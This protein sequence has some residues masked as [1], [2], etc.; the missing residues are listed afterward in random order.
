V[1]DVTA[2]LLTTSS[3]HPRD[4]FDYWHEMTCRAFIPYECQPH[5]RSAFEGQIIALPFAGLSLIISGNNG[6]TTWRPTLRT[7][8]AK[9]TV[10]VC[11]QT[12]GTVRISQNG[13]D[14]VLQNGDFALVDNVTANAFVSSD[15]SK[16]L[17]IELSRKD[18]EARLGRIEQWTARRVDG[19][20]GVGAL[21][22]KFVRM[23][24][25]QQPN[26][27]EAA[28]TQI[29][30]QV[31]DLVSLALTADDG[32]VPSHSSARF[33]SLLRLKA[34]VDANLTNG[35]ATCEELA[36]AA[37][38]SV[39]YANQLLEAEQ[40]SLQRLL[41]SRRIAKCQAA[42][43]DPAQSHRQISDIAYSWGFG[44]VSHF[45][46]LF[47]AMVGLTPRDFRR[48]CLETAALR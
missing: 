1:G 18:L 29:A 11:I 26:L 43:A 16:N 44:D 20:I 37:G 35:C 19:S 38:I 48:Q 32:N 24:P 41:F 6:V 2:H 47:K 36:A 34:A 3:V 45:G 46:R 10:Y 25:E 15:G 39:R 42:L 30:H 12:A 17:V 7:T 22:S 31:V 28:Q 23:L 21:A 33:V 5:D 14:A 13:S 9:D 4:R 40:T 27:S 8:Q